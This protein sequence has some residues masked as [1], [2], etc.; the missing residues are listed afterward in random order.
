MKLHSVKFKI[1]CWYTFILTVVFV[2]VLGGI[3]FASE[4]YSEDM[5]RDELLDEVKDLK[6]EMLRYPEHFPRQDFVSY[7]DDGVLLSIYD[8]EFRYLNGVLPDAFSLE[9]PFRENEIQQVQSRQE[10][11]FICDERL[12]LP[13]GSHIWIRGIHSLSA[14]VLM[15][16]RL[17]FLAIFAVPLLILFTAF[18]GYRLVQRSLRPV[19]ILTDTV[20]QITD[21]TNLSLRLPETGGKDEFSHLTETFNK[22]LHHLEQQFLREQEFSSDAAHELRTPV[23]VI[24]SHCEYS[25]AELELAPEARE[26]FQCIREKALQMSQLVSHLLNIARAESSQFQPVFE[27]TD[28]E[29]LAESAAD[30]LYEKAREK[31]IRLEIQN[32]LPSPVI[33][34]NTELLSRLFLNL[35]DNGIQYGRPGGFVRLAMEQ[36]LQ[37][38]CITVTDNGIGIP[39]ESLDKIW[40]RFYRA[41]SS[42]SESSGFGLGLFMA[43]YIVKLHKGS[44]SVESRLGAGSVFTILLPV[45]R[46]SA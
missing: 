25:L 12:T 18:L 46:P 42:R 38:V 44:I 45:S 35:L 37:N 21:S 41:D 13:D 6:E 33:Q 20:N 10:S 2:L 23:S 22:M 27:E 40:N 43:K 4:L 5:I 28:L 29:I 39:E 1:T 16:Q 34:G 3:F 31:D 7:Y 26:E 17:R 9:I 19:A 30:E 32:F 15:I 36:R 11:W 8:E 24:L 14:I